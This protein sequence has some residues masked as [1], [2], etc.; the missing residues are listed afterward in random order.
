LI[1]SGLEGYLLGIGRIGVIVRLIL[2]VAGSLLAYTD[3]ITALSGF[4]LALAVI[5]VLSIGKFGSG[6]VS[7]QRDK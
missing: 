4:F 1:A 2:F 6:C 3:R 5:V 7:V